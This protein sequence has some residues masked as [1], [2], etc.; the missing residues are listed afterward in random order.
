L[1]KTASNL[2]K[3]DGLEEINYLNFL[4]IY[5]TL[6]LTDLTG[7]STKTATRLNLVGIYSV[8]DLYHADTALLKSAFRS[9]LASYWYQ[10]IRGYEAGTFSDITKSIGHT[11][12]LPKS[13]SNP[14]EV[15]RVLSKLAE[16]V[17]IRLRKGNFVSQV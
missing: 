13:S 11:Y 8:L 17:A 2:K 3:P 4:S 9:V 14:L 6:S 10:K 7:I 12:T 16:K 1:A 5:Q 15:K